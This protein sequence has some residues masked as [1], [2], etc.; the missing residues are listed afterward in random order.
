MTATKTR[1]AH[2]ECN[3]GTCTNAR[4][5]PR[6]EALSSTPSFDK[7]WPHEICEVGV[8]VSLRERIH[9]V[10]RQRLRHPEAV[11]S[12]AGLCVAAKQERRRSGVGGR[13]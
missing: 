4:A 11:G 12:I 6:T 8:R 3:T 9:E 5:N 13:E 7:Q 2:T 10:P 1:K